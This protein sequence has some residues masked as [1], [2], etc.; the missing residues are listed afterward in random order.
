MRRQ[1]YPVFDQPFHAPDPWANFRV[2]LLVAAACLAYA[3]G[4]VHFLGPAECSGRTLTPT[5]WTAIAE[6]VH[7]VR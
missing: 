5:C 2:Y 7:L 6:G 3:M 4:A 1:E